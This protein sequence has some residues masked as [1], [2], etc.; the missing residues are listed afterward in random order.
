MRPESPAIPAGV[1]RVDRGDPGKQ[2]PDPF[3]LVDHGNDERAGVSRPRSAPVT[4]LEG[5]SRARQISAR[6]TFLT[7]QATQSNVGRDAGK[8]GGLIR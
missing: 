7:M 2:R 5:T 1:T 3:T 6:V 4:S 8:S